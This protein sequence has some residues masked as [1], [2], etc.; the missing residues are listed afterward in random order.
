MTSFSLPRVHP[1]FFSFFFP[2]GEW[3]A[4]NPSSGTVAKQARC[5]GDRRARRVLQGLESVSR[6]LRENASQ[7]RARDNEEERERGCVG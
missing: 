4:Q 6:R 5:G 7:A 1:I 2:P 3:Q